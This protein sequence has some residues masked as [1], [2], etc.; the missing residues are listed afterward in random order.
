MSTFPIDLDAY[1]RISLD[2]SNSTLTDEQRNA[3]KSNIQ[4]C[5]DALIFLLQLVLPE[6]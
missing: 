5:R 6:V 2:S 4:L 3:I 1:Q